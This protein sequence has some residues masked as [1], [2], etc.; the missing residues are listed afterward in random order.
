ML[1]H[2]AT[3]QFAIG[4]IQTGGTAE[5]ITSDKWYAA[6]SEPVRF[7]PGL[8]ASQQQFSALAD[9]FPFVSFSWFNEL[10]IPP[11]R[12]RPGLLPSQQQ[13]I[14]LQ[15]APSP[16]VATGWYVAL[17]E[18]AR[19]LPGLRPGQQ[20]FFAYAPDQLTV[21]PHSWFAAL[22]EPV[23]FR[24]GLHPARQQFFAADT[25]ILP[26][27]R[28][29]IPWYMALSEPVRFKPGLATA[30]QQFLAAPSQLRPN[31]TT[32][33]VLNALETK[34]TFLAGGQ[35]WNRVTQAE[36]GVTATQAPIAQIG[37][38]VPIAITSAKIA[39]L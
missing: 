17:S 5:T 15:P 39:I 25:A 35:S 4:E 2:G 14:A 38:A 31:P 19:F 20:Q 28:G 29:P 13:F 6:L 18:P 21:V 37:V 27:Q 1:G 32:T 23:R 7:R 33:G 22:S 36:I 26:L 3:G 11:V 10:A 30:R 16:F 34:D 8:N 24:Q 9:P 12:T